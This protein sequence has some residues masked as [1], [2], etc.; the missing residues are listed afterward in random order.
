MHGILVNFLVW[1]LMWQAIIGTKHG[2]DLAD[3]AVIHSTGPLVRSERRR[4][5][6]ECIQEPL[7]LVLGQVLDQVLG[8]VSEL[9]LGPMVGINN[10][11]CVIDIAVIRSTDPLIRSERR[12]N[13]LDC[14]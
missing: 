9:V 10:H 11:H 14:T 12:R 5:L 6:L 8:Q 13:L 3:I 7:E 2:D 4:N 1:M